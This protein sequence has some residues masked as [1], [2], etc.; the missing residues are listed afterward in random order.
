M[1]GAITLPVGTIM[2]VVCA[3]SKASIVEFAKRVWPLGYC[4]ADRAIRADFIHLAA[5]PDHSGMKMFI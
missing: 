4:A 2:Y 5:Q 1:I 3:L